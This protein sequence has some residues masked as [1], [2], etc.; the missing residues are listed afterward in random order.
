MIAGFPWFEEWGRD[1]F[2]A[3]PGLTLSRGKPDECA[4]VLSG[5]VEYLRDGLLPNIFGLGPDDSHYGSAD[6]ALW[7]ARAVRLYEVGGRDPERVQREYLPALVEIA[8]H[9]AKGT[10]LGIRVDSDGLLFAGGPDLN[11][12]WMDAQTPDGPVTPR[13]G[14]PVELNALYYSLL[15]H[16]EQLTEG[17]DKRRWTTLRRK[18]KRAFLEHFWLADEG[19]LADLIAD[20]KADTSVRPN[21]VF[22]AALEFSPLTRAQRAAIVDRAERD[23]LTPHGLRTLSPGSADYC[24]VYAGAPEER[25][26]AYHQGTVWPW[27]LGFYTEAALR[28]RGTRKSV[29]R[30]LSERWD[31]LVHEADKAGL[32]HLSEVFDADAPRKPGGS[33]AQAWNTA[34]F[35]RA[36][37][38]LAAGKP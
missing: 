24:P 35:L 9:H 31:T 23:L 8:E 5:A 19:Y 15:Q 10:G 33:I 37:A 34:E 16:L 28:A 7:F 22:A 26:G 36:K 21:M 6:A 1:T 14:A 13:A 3:L 17:K 2:I 25:D 29:R 32:N 4:R 20:G 38:M 18:T 27:L 30:D 12:T 11:P